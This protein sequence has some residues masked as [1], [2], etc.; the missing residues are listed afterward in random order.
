MKRKYFAL[1]ILAMSLLAA[2]AAGQKKWQVDRDLMPDL[3]KSKNYFALNAVLAKYSHTL[4]PHMQLYYGTYCARAFNN[5]QLSLIYAG[6]LLK[7]YKTKFSDTALAGILRIKADDFINLYQYRKAS[8]VLQTI[9]NRYSNILDSAELATIKNSLTLFKTISSIPPQRIHKSGNVI[10]KAHRN[11]FNHLMTAVQSVTDTSAFIFDS[12]ANFSVVSESCA[13]KMG[14]KIYET[15]IDVATSTQNNV[16][17]KLA[18]A[19]SF[20]VGELLFE[21]VIFL[22]TRDEDM[23]FPELDYRVNGIIGFPMICQMGEVKIY[24][25]SNIMV[26]AKPQ[27]KNLHN[28]YFDGLSPIVQVISG[29]DTLLFAFDTGAK[30][31]KLSKKY[32]EEH[33]V[34]VEENG[35]PKLT[36]NASGGGIMESKVYELTDFKYTIGSKSG[37]LNKIPVA[38]SDLTFLKNLDGNL[39]QD[40][41][42]KFNVLVLN[43]KSMYINF[44]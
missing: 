15:G 40:V 17:T 37:V 31:S 10:I 32:Y 36:K 25:D 34:S 22:V 14:F 4:P 35:K 21:N 30:N 8:E 19:D 27:I 12:G 44:E 11:R 16:Q 23:N 3:L 1:F 5:D 43:F 24:K 28:L 39:G 33:K 6:K 38:I 7:K 42:T 41:F 13:K 2:N 18:I 20:Y 26:P 29:N 9:V